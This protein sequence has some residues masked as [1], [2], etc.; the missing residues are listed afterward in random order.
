MY[1]AVSHACGVKHLGSGASCVGMCPRDIISIGACGDAREIYS[2]NKSGSRSHFRLIKPI[3]EAAVAIFAQANPRV[4]GLRGQPRLWRCGICRGGLPLESI[5]HRSKLFDFCILSEILFNSYFL[6][7]ITGWQ[8]RGVDK[9]FTGIGSVSCVVGARCLCSCLGGGS[10]GGAT[11]LQ[12]ASGG[13]ARGP[14]SGG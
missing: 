6:A 11:P 13:S 5:L 8:C 10:T 7:T 12:R 2:S 4:V 9:A 14:A 1:L 3:Q